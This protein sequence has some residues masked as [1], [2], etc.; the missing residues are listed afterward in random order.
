MQPETGTTGP[1]T[2]VGRAPGPRNARAGE[3]AR[4]REATRTDEDTR[5]RE[6]TIGGAASLGPARQPRPG[7]RHP[8]AGL[9]CV[10]AAAAAELRAVRRRWRHPRPTRLLGTALLAALTGAITATAGAAVADLVDGSARIAVWAAGTTALAVAAGAAWPT[11]ERALLR[12]L[13]SLRRD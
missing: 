11:A 5:C 13:R 6:Q 9:P 7:H 4:R 2:P 8:P 10:L 1:M 12:L 3:A